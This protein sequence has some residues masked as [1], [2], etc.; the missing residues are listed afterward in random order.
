MEVNDWF[1][2]TLED[3]STYGE[4]RDTRS[5]KVR[6]YFCPERFRSDPLWFGKFPLWSV[7]KNLFKKTLRE[8]LFFLSGSTKVKDMPSDIAKTWWGPWTKDTDDLGRF[9]SY[10]LRKKEGYFD[11]IKYLE[12][13]IKTDPYG[14]RHIVSAFNNADIDKTCLPSCHMSYWQFYCRSNEL[15]MF[16]VQRSCDIF[17]GLGHNIAWA[18]QFLILLANSVGRLPGRLIY[19]PA[20]THYY[21]NHSEAA[22]KVLAV[23]KAQRISNPKWLLKPEYKDLSIDEVIYRSM[24]NCTNSRLGFDPPI[25]LKDYE[26]VLKDLELPLSA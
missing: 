1:H 7:K 12:E 16:A 3:I 4:D 24:K 23:P 19:Q 25:M 11:Q 22:E 14:R 5:G 2:Q 6:S 15:D 26:P 18:A 9:Y 21:L 10:Q 13:S 8:G 20:D 17:L